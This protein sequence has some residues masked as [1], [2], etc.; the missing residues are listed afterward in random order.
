M[1]VPV[2]YACL[3]CG[4]GW[5]ETRLPTPGQACSA[6]F[7][8]LPRVRPFPSPRTH[9]PRQG[10]CLSVCDSSFEAN[11]AT[12]AGG[13]LFT[14]SVGSLDTG[15]QASVEACALHVEHCAVEESMPLRCTPQHDSM[16]LWSIA[17]SIACCTEGCVLRRA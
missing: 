10:R 16:R 9:P 17:W 8:Q 5:L 13:A 15:T 2:V 12:G 3:A 6:L 4:A 14:A 7:R 1:Q 11:E